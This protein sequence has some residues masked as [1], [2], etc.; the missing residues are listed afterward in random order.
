MPKN[1]INSAPIRLLGK[2]RLEHIAYE[3]FYLFVFF[4]SSPPGNN[5]SHTC[6]GQTTQPDNSPADNRGRAEHARFTQN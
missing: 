4:P 6:A 3:R 5:R 2:E 1:I